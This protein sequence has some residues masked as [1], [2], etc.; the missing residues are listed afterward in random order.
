[1]VSPIGCYL[2]VGFNSVNENYGTPHIISR[3]DANNGAQL[4]AAAYGALSPAS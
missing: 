1:M 3:K 4:G 2:N